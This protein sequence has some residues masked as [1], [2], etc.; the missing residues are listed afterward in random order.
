VSGFLARF[1]GGPLDGKSLMCQGTRRS[2]MHPVPD[3][4]ASFQEVYRHIEWRR[5]YESARVVIY[6]YSL[7]PLM[8]EKNC[9]Q[10]DLMEIVEG[11]CAFL[12]GESAHDQS[13]GV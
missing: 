8:A 7:S 10:Y 6:R 4:P 13:D 3:R 11:S 9:W 2:T 1:N 12:C 5:G